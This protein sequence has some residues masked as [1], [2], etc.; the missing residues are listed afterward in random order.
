[1]VVSFG[2]SVGRVASALVS[3]PSTERPSLKWN[4]RRRRLAPPVLPSK[5]LKRQRD[6]SLGCGRVIAKLPAGLFWAPVPGANVRTSWRTSSQK[7]ATN[8]MA[9]SAQPISLPAAMRGRRRHLKPRGFWSSCAPCFVGR[10]PP[11]WSRKIPPSGSKR[12]Q[13]RKAAAFRFGPRT[14]W[15]GTAH[16]GPS[17]PKSGFGWTCCSS[18][19]CAAAMSSPSAASM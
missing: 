18:L 19:G 11:I 7:L 17:G 12:P 6:H 13:N 14:M 10:F 15:T 2:I 1:M 5:A 9:Q 8:R 3:A 4:M 16:I